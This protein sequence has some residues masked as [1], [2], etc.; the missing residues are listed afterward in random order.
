[1]ITPDSLDVLTQLT[2]L[3]VLDLTD[4]VKLESSK[5]DIL[6][7]LNSELLNCKVIM[8]SRNDKRRRVQEEN[9]G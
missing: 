3:K 5:E 6:E 1:M 7:T 9:M 4:C 2:S 8:R